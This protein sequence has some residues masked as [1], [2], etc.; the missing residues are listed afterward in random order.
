MI[1]YMTKTSRS[2]NYHYHIHILKHYHI[3]EQREKEKSGLIVRGA[4]CSTE[5]GEAGNPGEDAH[6]TTVPVEKSDATTTAVP[7]VES[8][9]TWT[10]STGDEGM[11]Y[12]GFIQTSLCTQKV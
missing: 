1:V 11:S 2:M 9:A 3:N 4:K 5:V 10:T 7:V 6:N 8:D 12:N